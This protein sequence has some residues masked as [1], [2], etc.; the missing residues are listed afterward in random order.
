MGV[1]CD[2]AVAHDVIDVGDEAFDSIFK[3]EASAEGSFADGV[4]GSECDTRLG[5]RGQ[6][7]RTC[8]CVVAAKVTP[9]FSVA[10]RS[11]GRP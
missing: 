2:D 10:L 7:C 5:L 8:G 9:L 1:E 4:A 3:A 6:S 11:S